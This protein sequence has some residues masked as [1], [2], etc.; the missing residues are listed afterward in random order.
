MERQI[1][2]LT[3]FKYKGF[4]NAWWAFVQMGR[5]PKLLGQVK[6]LSFVKMLG[7]GGKQGFSILPNFG[8]YGLLCVWDNE[9]A[10]NVFFQNSLLFT[11]L[12]NKASQYQTFFLETLQTHG[13]WD[14][15]EPFLHQK[16]KTGANQKIAV[17]TRASIKW[18]KLWQFWRVVRPASKDMY[19][20]QG[21]VFSVGIGELPLIQQATFSIWENIE[22][23]TNYAYKSP[24]H[25]KVLQLTKKLNWYSE[26]LFARFALVGTEGEGIV[27]I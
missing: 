23:M 14:G 7:S 11:K 4:K 26:E 8:L 1:V 6:G 3:F 10:C 16:K 13:K 17:I 19:Q 18:S 15:K 25:K 2:T 27:K 5:L 12:K 21:L 20:H 24:Q 22:A 9:A